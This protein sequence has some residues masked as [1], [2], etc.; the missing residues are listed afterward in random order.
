MVTA[1]G[2]LLTFVIAFFI[3]FYLSSLEESGLITDAILTVFLLWGLVTFD[4]GLVQQVFYITAL[5]FS[6]IYKIALKTKFQQSQG[7][8]FGSDVSPFS[9]Q[10]I[11]F[12][13]GVM[14]LISMFLLTNA[15]QLFQI[16]G[17]P[18]LSIGS[19]EAFKSQL[20]LLFA[21]TTSGMIGIIENSLVLA[22]YTLFTVFQNKLFW[23]LGPFKYLGPLLTASFLFGFLHLIAYGLQVQAIIWAMSIAVLWLSSYELLGKDRTAMDVG[24]SGW[25]GILTSQQSLQIV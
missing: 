12:F 1:F 2:Q 6:A 7:R 17:T 20:T 24:H 25:N 5:L 10:I 8:F 16:I 23:F 21:P 9:F 15:S 19:I 3:Y 18:T 13:S 4:I 14:I 22:L 11:T